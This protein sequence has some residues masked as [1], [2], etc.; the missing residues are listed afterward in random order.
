MNE[1]HPYDV[2]RFLDL[3]AEVTDSEDEQA[4]SDEEGTWSSTADI[5]KRAE[6]QIDEFIDD[7]ELESQAGERHPAPK[8]KLCDNGPAPEILVNQIKETYKTRRWVEAAVNE[9]TESW[10]E[11]PAIASTEDDYFEELQLFM[12]RVPV[13]L[14]RFLVDCLQMPAGRMDLEL[15]IC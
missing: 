6:H 14:I 10:P 4:F 15:K 9:Q 13:S 8:Q 11:G 1:S 2:T 12:V 5:T 7:T 3:V